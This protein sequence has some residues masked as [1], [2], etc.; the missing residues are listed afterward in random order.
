MGNSGEEVEKIT[1]NGVNGK[2]KK[3]KPP[4]QLCF[5]STQ[6]QGRSEMSR[7]KLPRQ[8]CKL[9]EDNPYVNMQTLFLGLITPKFYSKAFTNY[10]TA[11]LKVKEV[12][13]EIEKLRKEGPR[14]KY[15]EPVLES[16]W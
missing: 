11:H 2:I 13:E 5:A 15:E 6:E 1:E 4:F 16:H 12:S 8:T 7:P 9:I 14:E 10:S 3:G